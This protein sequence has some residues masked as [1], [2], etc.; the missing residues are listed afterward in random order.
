MKITDIKIH[1]AREWR[2]FLFVQVETDEGISGIGES[3]I[4]GRELAVAGALEHLKPLLIGQDPFRTEHHW[5]TSWR[6]GFYPAGQLLSAAIAAIDIA[7]WDIKGKALGVPV[8]Q[9]LGGRVREKVLT[10]NHVHASS[11]EEIVTLCLESVEQG[12]KCIRWE[13][14]AGEDGC[15]EPLG[16]ISRALAEWAAVRE[17][18]GDSIELC[19]DAHTKLTV[20]DAV[21]FCR[22]AEVF[23]P[24]FIE[25][26]IRSE[27]KSSYRHLRGQTAVPLAAGEQFATKWD[28]KSLVEEELIDYARLDLCIAGGFTEGR[29]IA[30]MCETHGVDIAVHNPLGPVSTAAC[31]HFNLAT[32]NMLVQ[33]LPKRPGECVPDLITG[34]PE[35]SDGYLLPNNR[36]GL[37]IEM[38]LEALEKYPFEMMELPHLHREDGTFTNW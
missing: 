28:F 19:F 24:L 36:P 29:K 1:L 6:G 17:A 12:W 33:E 8:H 35:W 31:L 38:T 25:D 37:G 20:P 16:A 21:R 10:Y 30:A 2:T 9:L 4:S 13:L 27:L 5:Q 7:L 26:P 3:G 14:F 32:P 15:F 11:T 22:E 34:Q 23:R 18:V